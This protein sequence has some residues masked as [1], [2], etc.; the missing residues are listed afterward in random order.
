MHFSY[1]NHCF[2]INTRE[3]SLNK[4]FYNLCYRQTGL[5]KRKLNLT[6]GNYYFFLFTVH[7]GFTYG[8]FLGHRHLFSNITINNYCTG[9]K[10][11]DPDQGENTI[12]SRFF[13]HSRLMANQGV[14]V[15]LYEFL[16]HFKL[17]EMPYK[18]IFGLVRFTLL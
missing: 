8:S 3:C 2:R 9:F 18:E 11:K 1:N 15:S 4:W 10:P 14:V 7:F 17:P 5:S 12:S 6:N 13:F 16:N